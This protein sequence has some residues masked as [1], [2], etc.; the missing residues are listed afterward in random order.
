MFPQHFHFA[1]KMMTVPRWS[2]S[3]PAAPTRNA[4]ATGTPAWTPTASRAAGRTGTA[5]RTPMKNAERTTT[6]WCRARRTASARGTQ[7]ATRTSRFA[8]SLVRKNWITKK[9]LFTYQ[10]GL[11]FRVCCLH[12]GGWLRA[13]WGLQEHVL[14]QGEEWRWV[15]VHS[16]LLEENNISFLSGGFVSNLG[17]KSQRSSNFE[18]Q[19]GSKSFE[20]W[21]P[22][23]KHVVHNKQH[24]FIKMLD[25]LDDNNKR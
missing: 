3:A 16:C 8:R 4:P 15:S 20:R 7:S 17:K 22:Q 23:K 10:T 14:H 19:Q 13:G 25:D 5:M 6:A 11:P 9:G 12:Q 2:S 24:F 21:S 18:S 1:L